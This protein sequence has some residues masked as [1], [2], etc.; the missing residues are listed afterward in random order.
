[1][2]K[3]YE[4]AISVQQGVVELFIPIASFPYLLLQHRIRPT[5]MTFHCV[6]DS[7]F[8]CDPEHSLLLYP[9]ESLVDTDVDVAW[10]AYDEEY[11]NNL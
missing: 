6:N 1:M 8:E 7:K 3:L 9:D 5:L 10:L 4:T 2:I 11:E